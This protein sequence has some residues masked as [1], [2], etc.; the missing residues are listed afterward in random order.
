MSTRSSVTAVI[1]SYETG[2]LLLRAINSLERQTRPPDEIV[3]VDDGSVTAE[4]RSALNKAAG[5]PTVQVLRQPENAGVAAARN[6]GIDE[7]RS[8]YVVF[9][10]SDDM[11]TAPTIAAYL[12][13]FDDRP[14]ADFAYPTVQ[15]FG[16]R[17]DTFPPPPF[18]AY[19]LHH[20]NICPI[21]SMVTRRA[22]ESGVRFD[23]AI[24]IGHEDWDFWLRLVAAGA[25]GVAVP[26]ATLLYRRLGFT[27]NDL[28]NQMEGGFD[29]EL[30]RLRPKVFDVTRLA[31]LKREW[32]P[33]LTVRAADARCSRM[34]AAHQTCEDLEVLSVRA[35]EPSRGHLVTHEWDPE[36]TLLED[37]FA[38]EDV[39]SVPDRYPG[40]EWIIHVR[41]AACREG[42]ASGPLQA[43]D[44]VRGYATANDIVAVTRRR[45][46]TPAAQ[47]SYEPEARYALV[48]EFRRVSV[49]APQAIIWR[50]HSP[51][52]RPVAEA[53]AVDEASNAVTAAAARHGW[54]RDVLDTLPSALPWRRA[55]NGAGLYLG[56]GQAIPSTMQPTLRVRDPFGGES[57]YRANEGLLVGSEILRGG[58]F[59]HRTQVSGTAP[60][61]RVLDHATGQRALALGS[62]EPGTSAE[63]VVGYIDQQAM[64][65]GEPFDVPA[66]AGD[67]IHRRLGWAHGMEDPRLATAHLHGPIL[68]GRRWWRA[69]LP[70][71]HKHVYG[72]DPDALERAGARVEGPVMVIEQGAASGRHEVPVRPLMDAHGHSVG[73][74]SGLSAY[75]GCTTGVPVG[76]VR[77]EPGDGTR[78]VVL[79]RNPETGSFLC[80][81][82]PTEGRDEGFSPIET[83][84][85]AWC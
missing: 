61:V 59:L 85:Y 42:T 48:D 1:P 51:R 13:A 58:P 22:L 50:M 65:G 69:V 11:F 9:L 12:D 6:R 4:A 47:A 76:F 25:I 64:P 3:V 14:D 45:D 62:P 8:D 39:L 41:A 18:N 2:E 73:L 74:T 63:A 28:G 37:P 24:E 29:Q 34:T 71:A 67:T 23:P 32:A 17:T 30:R 38:V 79:S 26:E 78:Q 27:R 75:E 60:V 84:G 66:Q 55:A 10:D 80:S 70:E 31:D 43:M 16:G 33:A 68:D 49:H 54:S 46:D 77:R 44:F 15:C 83:L 20:V 35:P 7:S 19:L 21:A 53:T 81:N 40:C 36:S 5:R 56:E 72:F 52:R 57:L 82:L